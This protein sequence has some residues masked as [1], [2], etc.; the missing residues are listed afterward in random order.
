[1][2]PISASIVISRSSSGAGRCS[3]AL[4][5]LARLGPVTFQC[6]LHDSSAAGRLAR[7]A[8]SCIAAGRLA[9]AAACCIAPACMVNATLAG[10]IPAGAVTSVEVKRIGKRLVLKTSARKGCRFESVPPPPFHQ[11]HSH[12]LA[13]TAA[14]LGDRQAVRQPAL[15]RF[16]AGSNPALPGSCLSSSSRGPSVV[17]RATRVQIP[18]GTP[19]EETHAA[20]RRDTWRCLLMVRKPGFQPGNASSILVSASS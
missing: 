11:R 1:M 9:R 8:A 17:I 6:F 7:K 18:S 2:F 19:F 12:N 4:A 5:L 14:L 13:K 20:V 3:P 15:N 16:I 10:S